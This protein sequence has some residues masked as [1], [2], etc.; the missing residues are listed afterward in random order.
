MNT[1]S[2]GYIQRLREM[3]KHDPDSLEALNDLERG[4]EEVRLLKI[5]REH[6]KTQEMIKSALQRYKSGLNDL[7]KKV[8]LSDNDR[9][10]LLVSMDWAVWFLDSVGVD[11]SETESQ[12][13]QMVSDYAKKA[14]LSTD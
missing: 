14:G 11:P 12:I 9:R 4:E 5:Y 10:A 2:K 6:P 3:Y 13:D 7:V 8:D 1:Q